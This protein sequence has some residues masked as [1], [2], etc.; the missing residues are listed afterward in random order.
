MPRFEAVVEKH[1]C[2]CMEKPLIFADKWEPLAF[3]PEPGTR[4]LVVHRMRIGLCTVS[5]VELEAESSVAQVDLAG[6][7]ADFQIAMSPVTCSFPTRQPRI[8]N[9]AF[10]MLD[11]SA[12]LSPDKTTWPRMGAHGRET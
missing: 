3:G 9:L 8:A 1:K 4:D 7:Q 2:V 5:I 11:I 6:S 10:N 12:D